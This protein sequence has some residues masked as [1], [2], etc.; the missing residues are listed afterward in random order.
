MDQ[1]GGGL[2]NGAPTYAFLSYPTHHSS[3]LPPVEAE[4]AGRHSEKMNAPMCNRQLTSI[5]SQEG[6]PTGRR[7]R[8]HWNPLN[9]NAR[10]SGSGPALVVANQIPNRQHTFD[11][12]RTRQL[13][14]IYCNP[15]GED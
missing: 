5:L 12:S 8:D 6:L 10:R 1:R 4:R 2:S 13:V 7:Q 11:A 15:I 3:N 9:P 14:H